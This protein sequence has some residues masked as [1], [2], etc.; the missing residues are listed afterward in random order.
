MQTRA[1]W[2]REIEGLLAGTAHEQ[3]ARAKTLNIEATSFILGVDRDQVGLILRR[4]GFQGGKIG[5]SRLFDKSSV[6]EAAKLAGL[7][8]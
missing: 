2:M 7:L 3:Y 1:E 8:S 4:A 5:K 6:F